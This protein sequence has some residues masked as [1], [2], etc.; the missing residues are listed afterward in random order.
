[1]KTLF[2]PLF[3]L[4]VLSIGF[5][6]YA[7]DSS[8][9]LPDRVATHFG[10]D[11]TP[12]DWMSKDMHFL[13]MVGM[14]LGIPWLLV[15]IGLVCRFIPARFVNIPNRDYW[16]SPERKQKSCLY[17][18]R[19]MIWMSCLTIAFFAGVQYTIV[20]ANQNSPVKIPNELFW[21]L[22]IGFLIATTIWSIAL[23]LRFSKKRMTS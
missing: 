4:V 7:H 14:G 17:F 1:M 2:W 10:S 22:L 21:P 12:N 23:I 13:L 5:L 11:G 9:A 3:V 16:F 20:K 19:Y 18:S 8:A 6:I 15:C